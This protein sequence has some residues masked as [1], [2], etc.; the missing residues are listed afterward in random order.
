MPGSDSE[1]RRGLAIAR[2]ALDD[3]DH[4][5]VDGHNEW[6]MVRRRR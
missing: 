3:L 4:Q 2:V 5:R 6:T 1:D